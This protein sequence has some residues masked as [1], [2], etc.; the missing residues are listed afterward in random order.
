MMQ[1]G[2]HR[3]IFVVFSGA[4]PDP[5]V[6]VVGCRRGLQLAA[7]RCRHWGYMGVET[8][9]GRAPAHVSS[10][11]SSRAHGG[12]A[13]V[14]P[15]AVLSSS[16]RGHGAQVL[17]LTLV[18]GPPYHHIVVVIEGAQR[19]RLVLPLPST[20]LSSLWSVA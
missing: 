17:R 1:V 3:H 5:C 7:A 13:R 19:L 9:V 14:T 8:C 16:C 4:S 11:S 12:A 6:F 15:A 2:S 10:L 18:E 20:V